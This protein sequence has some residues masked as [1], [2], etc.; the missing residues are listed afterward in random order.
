MS[1]NRLATFGLVLFM[2]AL[3]GGCAS[4]Q[5]KSLSS[6]PEHGAAMNEFIGASDSVEVRCTPMMDKEMAKSYLG[7]EPSKVEMVPVLFKV[8][9]NGTSPIKVDI[10]RTALI[11]DGAA[12]GP[13]LSLDDACNKARRGEGE[14]IGWGIA[15]GAVGAM[16]SGNKVAE[17]NRAL[18]SDYQKKAFKPTLINA[19]GKGEGV[20][21][22]DVPKD[23]Q[24][25]VRSV[26]LSYLDLS[27]SET[28]EIHIGLQR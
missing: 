20:L 6:V 25:L 13:C 17:A 5:T 18:E 3:I 23:R 24:Q 14:V 11:L 12:D 1:S 27:T 21:F 15:F 8:Q 7:I 2:A 19:G 22:F 4:Y 10:S 9:N 26:R 16:A 28:R